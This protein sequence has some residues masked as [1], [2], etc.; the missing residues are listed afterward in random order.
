IMHFRAIVAVAFCAMAVAGIRVPRADAGESSSSALRG[1]VSVE[2]LTLRQSVDNTP[3]IT[4]EDIPAPPDATY[5]AGLGNLRVGDAHG[6]KITWDTS[7]AGWNWRVGGFLS[8]AFTGGGTFFDFSPGESTNTSYSQAAGR[9]VDTENSEQAH[10]YVFDYEARVGGAEVNAASGDFL[11]GLG[12]AHFLFGARTLYYGYKLGSLAYDDPGSFQGTG[13]NIDRVRITGQNY[14]AGPQLGV[15][16]NIPLTQSIEI[17]GTLKGSLLANVMRTTRQFSSDDDPLNVVNAS[18]DDLRL[19]RAMEFEPRVSMRL[20]DRISLVARGSLLWLDGIAEASNEYRIASVGSRGVLGDGHVLM[21]GG[22]VGLRYRFSPAGDD[23]TAKPFPDEEIDRSQDRVQ[24]TSRLSL[25]ALRLSAMH[26]EVPLTTA[27]DDIA[28]H[29]GQEINTGDVDAGG[30]NG[31]RAGLTI[32]MER[33]DLRISA[34]YAGADGGTNTVTDPAARTSPTYTF[35]TGRDVSTS[36][37]VG[38]TVFEFSHGNR[39]ASAEASLAVPVMDRDRWGV[40]ALIGARGVHYGYSLNSTVY[41]DADDYAG[42][43]NEIDRVRVSGDNFLVGPQ[44]GVEG[45]FVS[46]EG[47]TLSASAKAGFFANFISGERQFSSDN[48]PANAARAQV[49]G[50]DHARVVELGARMETPLT[51]SISLGIGGMILWL[52]GISEAAGQS[53]QAS[54]RDAALDADGHVVLYGA[55]IGLTV[56]LN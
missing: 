52:D 54:N 3:L 17:G 10:A 1:R 40:T 12:D 33:S 44:I 16:V 34:F 47:I 8:S 56:A 36:N 21:Y 18:P 50:T 26:D 15:D 51:D 31:A 14:M 32:P 43:D 7:I 46:P 42:A 19:S 27:D 49:S 37:S 2:A 20:S 24:Q 45:T 28:T 41:D 13:T 23:S 30:F 48:D 29:I 55:S 25:E 22:S 9:T 35:A 5:E 6:A 4:A 38:A 53:R 11:G 39:I